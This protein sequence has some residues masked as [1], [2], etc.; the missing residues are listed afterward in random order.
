MSKVMPK[1]LVALLLFAIVLAGQGRQ[2]AQPQPTAAAP[3]AS[4]PQPVYPAM[5]VE[6]PVV[7]EHQI[8]VGGKTIKYKATTGFMPLA[9]DAGEVEANV[10]FVAYTADTGVAVNKRP[11]TF[12]FNGG[13]GAGSLWLHMG[14]LGP[15]RTKMLDDGNLP[16]EPYALEDN[17]Y[18]WL[19]MTDLV[20]IDPVGTGYSRA[21]RPDLNRKFHSLDGDIASVGEVIRLYLTRYERWSSPLFLIGE[22]Y[23]TTRA[24]GLSGYLIDRGIAFNGIYLVSTILNFQTARFTRGNDLPY[25]LFLPTYSAIAWYHKKLGADFKDLPKLVAEVEH[26]AESSYSEALNKGDRLTAA[27]RQAVI[28]KLHA[29][30]GLDKRF[31]DETDLRVEIQRFC[32]ELLRDR[33]QTVGRLD[34]RIKGEEGNEAAPNP[35]FDPSMTAIRPPYTATMNDYARRE[36]GFKTDL[37]YYAL[38][39]GV[40]PWDYGV[41]NGFADTA[42]ALRSALSKNSYMKVFV[43]E[44]YYD[45]ATPFFAAEYTMNHMGLASSHRGNIQYHKYEAGHMIYTHIPSLSRFK[46]EATEFMKAQTAGK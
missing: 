34:G 32:K 11:L 9:N 6:P 39:G 22:S 8:T 10:F 18:T 45:L 36:L 3:A 30:T 31:L 35:E 43:A 20:F 44:G 46:Q 14:A 5:K 13:P 33:K 24:A 12:S 28:D 16:A 23:G 40:G 37:Q 26:W 1:A 41:Q 19:D 17:P 7:T 2:Q 25:M 4:G 21:Q 38:G 15:R 29:Y 27:E 42:Q